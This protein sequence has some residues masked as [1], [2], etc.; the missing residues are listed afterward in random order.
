MHTDLA[1]HSVI[2]TWKA[3]FQAAGLSCFASF[4]RLSVFY[5]R[6]DVQVKVLGNLIDGFFSEFHQQKTFYKACTSCTRESH[7]TK[8]IVNRGERLDAAHRHLFQFMMGHLQ[9]MLSNDVFYRLFGKLV[10]KWSLRKVFQFCHPDRRSLSSS[11]L[12]L[13]RCSFFLE[14]KHRHWQQLLSLYQMMMVT[15]VLKRQ[16][17]KWL[18]R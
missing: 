9:S 17:R 10:L 15:I 18:E 4:A 8:T 1:S 5:N 12:P 13:G 11:C 3:I 7:V 16:P 6:N 2:N 14:L